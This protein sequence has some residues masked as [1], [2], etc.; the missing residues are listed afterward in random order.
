[1][2][3]LLK[4]K[5]SGK[6]VIDLYKSIDAIPLHNWEQIVQ[7]KKY[8]FLIVQKHL[9]NSEIDFFLAQDA[10]D[11]LNDQYFERMGINPQDD[12]YFILIQ[13]LIEAREKFMKGNR[14]AMN[15][16]KLITRQIEDIKVT[17]VKL[18]MQKNRLAVEKWFGP[19]DKYTKTVG[20]FIDI[21]KL[22][23]EEANGIKARN[24]KHDDHG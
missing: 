13:K 24:T 10:L 22:M 19:I 16:V 14:A 15:F 7:F 9:R 23:E 6:A 20:E 5:S 1:M 4:K 8:E 11:M 18:N 21:C 3:R 2:Q 17:E 12:E